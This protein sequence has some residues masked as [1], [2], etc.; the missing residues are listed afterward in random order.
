MKTIRKDLL[1]EKTLIEH[2]LLEKEVLMNTDHPFMVN[3]EYVFQT[4]NRIF[5]IMKF[6][7]GGELYRHLRAEKQFS[8]KR[9]KFYVMQVA[10]AIGHLHSMNVVYRDLKPENILMDTD[11]YIRLTDFGLS[12]SLERSE[13]AYTFC[14]TP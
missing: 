2:C 3:M 1:L 5:F 6:V 14:G 10:L 7:R 11:G 9:A 13:D 4:E 12:K 8:E